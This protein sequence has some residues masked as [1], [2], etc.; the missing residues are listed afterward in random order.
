MFYRCKI[1]V[2]NIIPTFYLTL[3]PISWCLSECLDLY[4]LFF[5]LEGYKERFSI[6]QDI[7]SNELETFSI[8]TNP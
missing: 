7:Q 1:Y 3:I 5:V 6:Y 8:S 4:G 2:E